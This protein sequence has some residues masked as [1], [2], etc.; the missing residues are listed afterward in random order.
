MGWPR[1]SAT[2]Q[3]YAPGTMLSD[4]KVA[5]RALA[6]QPVLSIVALATLV[7]GIGANT[8]IFSLVKGVLLD[9]LPY[10]ASEELVVLREQKPQG[11]TDSVAP[12]TYVD[13]KARPSTIETMAAFRHVRRRAARFAEPARD[14]R[15]F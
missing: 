10:E 1:K 15:A 9:S 8:A 5:F 2:F 6:R 13:W 7:L 3:C 4:F 11:E 12:P 14:A